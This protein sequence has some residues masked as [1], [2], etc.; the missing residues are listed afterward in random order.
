MV[1]AVLGVIR[2][3]HLTIMARHPTAGRD[4]TG[5][6]G[7]YCE[8][9]VDA[10]GSGSLLRSVRGLPDFWRLLRLRVA[11]QFGDG[12]FQ[13]GLAGGLLFNPER[14]ASPWA[15]AG[16]F[17]VLFLPYSLLGPFAGALLDRWDRRAVLIGANAARVLLV[18]GVAGLLAAGA[19]DLV[20]LGGALAVNGFSRFVTS[21]LSAALPDVVPREQV[22]TMNSVATAAGAT[23]TFLGAIFMLLPRWLFGSGDAAAATVIALVAVPIAVALLLSQRFSPRV[24]GP[25]RLA[26]RGSA[27]Y[28]VATGWAYGLG[29]V[30]ATPAVASTL[31]GLAAH[32]MVFGVNS[33]LVLVIVRSTGTSGFA[34]L[35]TAVVFVGATG[36]GSFIANFLAPPALRRFGRYAV[37]N[38]ALAAAAL[39][40]LAGAGLHLAVMVLCGL[41]LGLAGQMVKLCGDS[42]MQIDV[43]DALRG[44][45]FAVQDAVFWMS[46]I[47]AVTAAAATIAPD[48]HSPALAVAGAAVYLL[49]L[50]AHAALGRQHRA[51]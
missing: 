21:G 48:G 6:S 13:A 49:G 27:L 34:G 38:A 12:L 43:D 23:A 4:A 10:P 8:P 42:A 31:S 24:L 35:G 5:A 47:A 11:S 30:R 17:A 7:L 18:L 44:H 19:R 9:V 22:V 29:A 1:G 37:A 36:L 45:V 3:R 46:F 14:A 32:R 16:A 39:I 41:F 40:Q 50:A 20:V 26:V 33:L 25:H 28:A 15:V 2:V 51:T